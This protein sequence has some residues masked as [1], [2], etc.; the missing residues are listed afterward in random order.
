[1][2]GGWCLVGL[3]LTYLIADV[4]K[5]RKPFL[6]LSVVGMNSLFIYLFAELD[7]TGF[8][9]R[10]VKPFAGAALEAMDDVYAAMIS[11]GIVWAMLWYLCFWLY[12]RKV[13]IKI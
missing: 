3:G 4:I 12:R 1:M 5:L 2:T 8:F 10:I 11:A 7:G 9:Q 6:F 13:F